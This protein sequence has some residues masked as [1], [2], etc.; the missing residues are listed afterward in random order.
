ML[1]TVLG[2]LYLISLFVTLYVLFPLHPVTGSDG[3]VN[4]LTGRVVRC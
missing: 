1:Q 3:L 2:K 4:Y